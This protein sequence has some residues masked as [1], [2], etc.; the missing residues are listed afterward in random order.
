MSLPRFLI[1]AP[2]SG[3]GKT[4]I[5]CGILQA[6][7]NRGLRV[8]SLAGKAAIYIHGITHE[9]AFATDVFTLAYPDLNSLALV[10]S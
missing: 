3:S 9:E 5:T 7:V 1:A 8:A 6:L 2:A 4:L 10:N